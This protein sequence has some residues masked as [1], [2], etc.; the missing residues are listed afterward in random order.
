MEG[1]GATM[2]YLRFIMTSENKSPQV[3]DVYF[4]RLSGLLSTL[5]PVCERTMEKRDKLAPTSPF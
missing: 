5:N 3:L 1:I 2:N 4:S